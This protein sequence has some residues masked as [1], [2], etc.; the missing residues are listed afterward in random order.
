MGFALIKCENISLSYDG[1]HV[2]QDLDFCV[3]QGDY[4]CIVGDHGGGK[5]TLI[6]ALL[7]HKA[8]DHGSITYGMGISP[9]GIGFLPQQAMFARDFSAT[10]R[11]V[12]MTSFLSGRRLF[13]KYSKAEKARYQQVIDLLGLGVLEE[14][15]FRQ[16]SGGQQ[17]RVLLARALCTTSGILVLDE[18][19]AGLDAL[20]A[21]EMYHFIRRVNR[22]EGVAVIM[23]TKDLN[24]VAREAKH[25]LELCDGHMTF[26]GKV[27]E[28]I[29]RYR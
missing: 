9:R 20:A 12:I 26:Y 13:V 4:L 19:A 8:P 27:Q 23:V 1:Q 6:K 25:V 24:C 22:Q 21:A 10:V 2:L 7:G 14:R 17:Q 11:E 15:T 18:P 3:E 5:T 29:D 28:Y 16:L